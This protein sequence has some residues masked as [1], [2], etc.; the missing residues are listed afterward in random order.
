MTGGT[1]EKNP[2]TL[3]IHEPSSAPPSEAARKEHSAVRRE[4]AAFLG[5]LIG[6]FMFLFL[7]FTG[8]QIALN[9]AGTQQ[10][11]SSDKPAPDVTKLIYIAFAFGVS[12]AINVAIFADISGGKFNPAVT[13]ALFLTGKITWHRAIQTII[14]QMIAGM[15]AAGFVSGLLPGPLIIATTLDPSMSTTR[16]LFLETFVTAQLVLT[17]LMLKGGSAKPMYIGFS[18]FIAEMCSVYFTG[19][20]LNPARSFGPAVVVGF[21]SYHWIYWV[22]PLLGAVL[23]SGAYA[24]IKWVRQEQE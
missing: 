4:I 2:Q 9:A 17:I 14:S 13:T 8:T 23:A 10:L 24:L 6:T 19:G 5:E 18:L 3:P 1:T 11:T 22:G 21:T 16:G 15:T 12:L 20:S 7:A